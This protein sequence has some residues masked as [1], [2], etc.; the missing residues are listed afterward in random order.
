MTLKKLFIVGCVLISALGFSTLAQAQSPEFNSLDFIENKLGE[1]NIQVIDFSPLDTDW[2][3]LSLEWITVLEEEGYSSLQQLIE[4][5]GYEEEFNGSQGLNELRYQRAVLEAEKTQTSTQD[6]INELNEE[7]VLITQ[8][9]IEVEN[10]VKA[11]L[12]SIVGDDIEE[13]QVDLSE[14]R[15]NLQ[16]QSQSIGGV[17]ALFNELDA[18]FG[19]AQWS[20]I[21][22][23][24]VRMLRE[25]LC[26]E[27]EGMCNLRR[28][29]QKYVPLGES[30]GLELLQTELEGKTYST[31]EG[32]EIELNNNDIEQIFNAMWATQFEGERQL[33]EVVRS[34]VKTARNILG[35]FAILWIVIAGIRMTLAQGDDNIMKEQKRAILYALLGLMV[36]LVLEQ[37]I[38]I[39]YGSVGQIQTNLQANAR[40]DAEVYG[41]V[42][43]IRAIMGVIAMA[44]LVRAGIRAI[45]AAG[46]E[47]EIKKQRQAI[48]WVMAGLVVIAINQVIIENIFIAPVNQDGVV[49]PSNIG[50]IINTFSNVFKFAL[51]FVGIVALGILVYGAALMIF[52]YGNDEMVTKAKTIIKNAVIGII[53]VIAAYTLVATLVTFG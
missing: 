2:G 20:G 36:I 44:I 53:I 28:L 18:Y 6:R 19:T 14:A 43:F 7:I 35:S 8:D 51:G 46:Q 3:S 4:K 29:A 15:E 5:E 21:P 17:N 24:V 48:A 11:S 52:N 47:D 45:F 40:F 13:A 39:L 33:T 23:S 26:A 22:Y 32:E 30:D 49:T 38:N 10:T 1:A 37:L 34:V 42:S 27:L 31:V 25:N 12:N 16:S 9:I 41:I 50:N